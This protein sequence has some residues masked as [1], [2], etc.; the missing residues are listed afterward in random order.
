METDGS[1]S[2][3]K[4]PIQKSRRRLRVPR[5][6]MS[7]FW[8]RRRL[9][10]LREL[11]HLHPRSCCSAASASGGKAVPFL[12]TTYPPTRPAKRCSWIFISQRGVRLQNF[13]IP[14]VEWFCFFGLRFSVSCH[15]CTGR[16]EKMGMVTACCL[17]L[18][19]LLKIP[20]PSRMMDTMSPRGEIY[21][22]RRFN[23]MLLPVRIPS[24]YSHPVLITMRA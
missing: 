1:S 8:R 10:L 5:V 16:D 12:S 18:L 2:I 19:L 7:R 13:D 17:L 6:A 14:V 23:R 15:G 24:D 4:S 3:S 21:C 9:V 11:E 22:G 20:C